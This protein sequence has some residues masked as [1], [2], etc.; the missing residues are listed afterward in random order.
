MSHL[1]YSQVSN[2]RT[3]QCICVGTSNLHNALLTM[4][5]KQ[6]Y[7]HVFDSHKLFFKADVYFAITK[8]P[9]ISLFRCALVLKFDKNVRGQCDDSYYYQCLATNTCLLLLFFF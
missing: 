6:T 7:R 4:R 2:E 3:S 9:S 8:L 1:L 5:L